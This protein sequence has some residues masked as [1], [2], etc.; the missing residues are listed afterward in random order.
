MFEEISLCPWSVRSVSRFLRF[1]VEYV[2]I[3]EVCNSAGE[4]A[5]IRRIGWHVKNLFQCKIVTFHLQDWTSAVDHVLVR[6]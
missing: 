5:Q 1:T 3:V 2:T 4:N 6:N